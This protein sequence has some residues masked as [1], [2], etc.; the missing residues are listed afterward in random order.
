M[1]WAPHSRGEAIDLPQA[2]TN[3]LS[4][5]RDAAGR[6]SPQGPIFIIGYMRSGTSLLYTLLNQHPLIALLYESSLPLLRLHFSFRKRSTTWL[7]RWD[8]RYNITSRHGLEFSSIDR[9]VPDTRT[10]VKTICEAYAVQ[11]GAVIWGDKSPEY[12]SSLIPIAL[13]FPDARFIVIWRNPVA[14]C[15]SILRAGRSA[16]GFARTWQVYRALLGSR[17]MKKETDRLLAQGAR[18]HQLQ[19]EELVTD[20]TA[21]MKNI[22]EFLEIHFDNE[23]VSL[24]KADRTPIQD[25][26]QHALVKGIKIVSERASSAEL[27]ANLEEKFQR[28]IHMWRKQTGGLWPAYPKRCVATKSPSAVERALDQVLYGLYR[29]VHFTALLFYSFAPL[30]VLRIYQ[31][32]R[33]RSVAN[34]STQGDLANAGRIQ[35]T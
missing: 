16:P 20:P 3:F 22:C 25:A 27:P 11:K 34:K 13:D 21:V 30:S 5:Q 1:S 32:F 28:Y 8:L 31:A 19:Y 9:A 14:I 29:A 26:A 10:A 35:G 23:M 12:Y 2:D 24:E 15:S 18:V 4:L 17:E 6:R 7:Q 33:T